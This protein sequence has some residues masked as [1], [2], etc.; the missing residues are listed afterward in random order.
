MDEPFRR[1][2]V[3]RALVGAGMAWAKDQG[4]REFAS[5]TWADAQHSIA[6]HQR[7]GFERV[8]KCVNFRRSID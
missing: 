4:C 7:L 6:A 3:G 1:Q 5:D 2:G 8:D